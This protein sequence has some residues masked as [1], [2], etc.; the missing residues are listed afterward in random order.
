[1]IGELIAGRYELEEMIG[2]GAT[3]TVFRARDRLLDRTVALKVLRERHAEDVHYVER[4]RREARAAARLGHP[5][6]VTVLDRGEADGY[7][8]IVFE[9]VRGENLKSLVERE[10][11]LPVGTALELAIQTGDALA[12]AHAHGL[13]HRD[14]KPQNVILGEDGR[15]RVTDFGIAR[16]PEPDGLTETGTLLGTCDYI[17]PEQATGRPADARSDVYSLGAVLY[18]LLTG[19]VPF[20][21]ESA[22]AVALRHVNDSPPRAAERRP[23]VPARLDAAVRRAMAKEP[24]DRFESMAALVTELRACLDEP[25]GSPGSE[26]TLIL[27]GRRRRSRRWLW[28]A[29]AAVVLL[30]VALAAA[31]LWFD[32]TGGSSGGSPPAERPVQ[33]TAVASYDPQG[34][35]REHDEEIRFATDGDF[36]TF[37][38]TEHYRGQDLGGLKDGVGIVLDAGRP[39]SLSRITVRSATPGFTAEIEAGGAMSGPF[40]PVSES[41]VVDPST[42]FELRSSEDARYYLIWITDLAPVV[43]R[44]DINEVT[45]G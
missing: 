29:A 39:V 40:A 14:V 31:F 5:N 17:S 33:L 2:L 21:G 4:F 25:E 23:A 22:V 37:W 6:I 34:D 42:T 24:E 44:A 10:G 3:S 41:R 15:A 8:Y 9:Y 18:E 12:F 38:E 35:G 30:A 7:Q 43:N 11:P 20:T 16:T 26:T 32:E 19:V 1:V 45:A 36:G 13:V 28:I 27:P